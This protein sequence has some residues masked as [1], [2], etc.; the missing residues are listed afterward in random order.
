MWKFK[1][2]IGG[3]MKVKKFRIPIYPC[4]YH[5]V[6]SSSND[7]RVFLKRKF[8]LS[9]REVVDAASYL[10]FTQTVGNNIIIWVNEDYVSD[11]SIAVHELFHV[12]TFS[13]EYI[14][15]KREGTSDEPEA[16][17]IQFLYSVWEDFAKE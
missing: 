14:G 15:H 11:N 10:G 1:K 9:E 12:V 3:L 6:I 16:Y 17:L 13:M 8:K 7:F 2:L 4:F 5:Y